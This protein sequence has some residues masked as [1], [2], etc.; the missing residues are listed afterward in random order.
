MSDKLRMKHLEPVASDDL[1]AE[2]REH[3]GEAEP[4]AE[5]EPAPAVDPRDQEE[6]TFQFEWTDS[7]GKTWKGQFTNKILDISEMQLCANLKARQL[8]GMPLSSFDEG[9]LV[10]TGAIA[11]MTVSLIKVPDWAKDL[12]KLKDT[13]LI[14]QLWAKVDGHEMRYFRLG[15][16]QSSGQ[17]A[18]E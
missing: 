8:G 7:R 18:S 5:N 14:L 13:A 1:I 12:R 3:M 9:T 2:A 10:V 4:H 16:D 17:S 6:W 11:H 15:E